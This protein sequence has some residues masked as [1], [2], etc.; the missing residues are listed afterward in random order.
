M[1]ISTAKRVVKSARKMKKV[2]ITLELPMLLTPTHVG[3]ISW[4]AQGWRPN[5]A[6]SQ[7]DSLHI[8]PNGNRAIAAMWSKRSLGHATSLRHEM[9][10]ITA[11]KSR[12][13]V[14]NPTITRKA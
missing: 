2:S 1:L 6:T 5:S 10:V 7:P 11:K 4:I 13:N 9:N 3:I 8:Y 12:N 14:P